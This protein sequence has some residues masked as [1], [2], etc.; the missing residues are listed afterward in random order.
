MSN[1]IT[2]KHIYLVRHG[3]S[4]WNV[5]N[6]RGKPGMSDSKLTELGES[7]AKITG[8][9]L[10]QKIKDHESNRLAIFSSSLVRAS[11]T[12]SIIA[13][14]IEH[15]DPIIIDDNLIE[16]QTN[17]VD[18][19]NNKRTY[20]QWKKTDDYIEASNLIKKSNAL[21]IIDPI[22]AHTLRELANNIFVTKLGMEHDNDQEQR[23]VQFWNNM[24][25]TNYSI[26]VVVS[27]KNIL[28][29]LNK[30]L[31][32]CAHPPFGN[33]R[34]GTNCTIEYIVHYHCDNQRNGQNKHEIKTLPNTIHLSSL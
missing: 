7:Q 2:T 33:L 15:S 14:Q 13:K 24:I 29:T 8:I 19:N 31:M 27:H 32:N 23:I 10:N 18:S 17:F 3:Q 1:L 28:R 20:S 12:A 6:S 25:N 5:H 16:V 21:E 30:Y 26:I 11:A 4:E 22:H 34:Y 9:Y